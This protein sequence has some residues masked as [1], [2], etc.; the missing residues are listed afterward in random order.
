MA[1]IAEFSVDHVDFALESVFAAH[2]DATVELDRVVPTDE[3]F[4]PYFWVWDADVDDVVDVA[5]VVR[6]ADPLSEM[7]PS[8]RWTAGACSAPG[9]PATWAACSP[10]RRRRT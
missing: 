8:T 1:V 7:E 6:E 3:A 9:G 4:L 5:D 2:A 10:R